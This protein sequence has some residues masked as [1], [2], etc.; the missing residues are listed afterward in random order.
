VAFSVLPSADYVPLLL[1]LNF[2][3]CNPLVLPVALS[4]F[5]GFAVSP[6]SFVCICPL[7]LALSG[8]L[9]QAALERSMTIFRLPAAFPAHPK[10]YDFLP[11]SACSLCARSEEHRASRTTKGERFMAIIGKFRRLGDSYTG[12]IQTLLFST[13]AALEA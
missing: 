8:D 2:R 12:T 9:K 11:G 1:W 3:Y 13:A 10:I 6:L 7:S 4:G 5:S